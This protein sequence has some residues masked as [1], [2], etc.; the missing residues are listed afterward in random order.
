MFKFLKNSSLIIL[1]FF[2]MNTYAIQTDWSN[3]QESQVRIISP[4]T[5]NN[6]QSE[7]ILGLEYRLEAGWKTYWR[8]SG[9]GGF[10]Q[11]INWE[12]SENIESIDILWPIPKYFEILGFISI[13][14]VNEVIFPLK[15]KIKDPKKN[16]K[17]ILDID[18]LTCKDICIPGSA[19][20]ELIIPQGEAS[21]T[22]NY[23]TIQKALSNVPKINSNNIGINNFNTIALENNEKI[24]IIVSVQSNN[25]IKNPNF[26]LHSDFGLPPVKPIIQQSS[27]LK[28]I[29]AIF[30]FNKKIISKNNFT[31]NIVFQDNNNIFEYKEEVNVEKNFN[32]FN[33]DNSILYILFISLIGGVI[34]NIMPCV[35]P[36]ISIKVLSIIKNSK[37]KLNIRKSFLITSSGIIS[38]FGLLAFIF[39]FLRYIGFNIGWGMQFQEPIFLIIISLILLLFS[40]NLFGFFEFRVPKFVNSEFFKKLNENKYFGDYFN[41]FFATILAT[42]CSAPFVGT[43]ITIAFTQS[44]IAMFGIFLFMGIGMAS[45]YL[46]I[47]A[48]PQMVNI[49]PKPGYWMQLIKYFLGIL[50]FATFIWILSILLNHVNFLNNYKIQN[51][52]DWL[53]FSLVEIDDLKKKH[54]VIFVDITADWCVTCQFN[55]INVINSKEVIQSFENNKVV[56]VRGDWTK[57][58]KKIEKFIQSFNRFGI[59][60][61]VI[62]I[63]SPPYEHVFSEL[64]SKE[65]ILDYINK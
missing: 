42:P 12:L 53:D 16:A 63:S 49:F 30:D 31:M 57:P 32:S 17:L 22:E 13:G 39:I 45:P 14:Y 47:S 7:I 51:E 20:L 61:N 23:F 11:N 25:K 36:V 38:S 35:L 62:Y 6:N 50:L 64:L 52:S 60:F 19:Y 54:S 56:K 15:V 27:N 48:F 37:H 5:H 44:S 3:S 40:L 34:L 43:A 46:L 2:A 21:Y 59:P 18:Y 41:G 10:P 29:K 28:N 33:F 1:L 24:S 65:E 58:N 4:L 55:K 8:S 26:F 9:E